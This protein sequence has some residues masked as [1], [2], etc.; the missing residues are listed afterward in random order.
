M[1]DTFLLERLLKKN[2]RETLVNLEGFEPNNLTIQS[3]ISTLLYVILDM[4]ERKNAIIVT[5]A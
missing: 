3:R 4:Q 5:M 2:L 1:V